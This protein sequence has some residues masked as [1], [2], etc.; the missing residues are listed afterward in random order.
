MD[1]YSVIVIGGG[2][3]GTAAA[4]ELGK[5]GERAIVFEQ[6]GHVHTMGAHSGQTRVIRHAYA[7][8]AGYIPL[9]LRADELWEEL[10]AEARIKVLHR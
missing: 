1:H 2:T 4:W 9:V 6:F 8:G 10:E 7:E 3:M 5:R